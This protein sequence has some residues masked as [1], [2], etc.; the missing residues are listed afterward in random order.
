MQTTATAA[1]ILILLTAP[2]D[3]DDQH[4]G[5]SRGGGDGREAP[6][7]DVHS[8]SLTIDRSGESDS[9]REQR[10]GDEFEEAFDHL[11]D[12][13]GGGF[14]GQWEDH[15]QGNPPRDETGP[16]WRR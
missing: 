14:S 6:R 2:A 7:G 16:G 13:G 10:I 5:H 11:Q 8:S 15:G 3:A 1:L 12:T 9:D 4:S